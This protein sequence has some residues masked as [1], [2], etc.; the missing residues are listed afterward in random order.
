GFLGFAGAIGVWV[1]ATAWLRGHH[2]PGGTLRPAR[3][4]DA[5]H[6]FRT[7]S[8]IRVLSTCIEHRLSKTPALG[9]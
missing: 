5:L 6:P 7:P 1:C 9:R 8:G 4:G 2:S 3:A